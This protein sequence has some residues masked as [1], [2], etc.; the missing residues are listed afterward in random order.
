M[1]LGKLPGMCSI[2]SFFRWHDILGERSCFSRLV[3][4]FAIIRSCRRGYIKLKGSLK[5]LYFVDKMTQECQVTV[6][7]S[8]HILQFGNAIWL[9]LLPKSF[10]NI[11]LH[12]K[13]AILV[14]SSILLQE[15]PSVGHASTPSFH[16]K[17]KIPACFLNSEVTRTDQ[18][19]FEI[20]SFGR[21]QAHS[22]Y[23]VVLILEAVENKT[24]LGAR[25]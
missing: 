25:Q 6:Q 8:I 19:K 21:D 11:F 2:L 1:E 7:T 20:E 15:S 12:F 17:R 4:F 9:S 16:P 23:V 22:H 18:E 24:K 14:T 5:P 13:T 10:H 3:P